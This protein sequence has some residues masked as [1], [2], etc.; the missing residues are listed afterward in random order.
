M[1]NE[2]KFKQ[3]ELTPTVNIT[4]LDS[5]YF[6][7]FLKDYKGTP[8]SHMPIELIYIDK[9]SQNVYEGNNCYTLKQG[10]IFIHKP[11]EVH[12]DNA[13]NCITTAYIISFTVDPD[14]IKPLFDKVITLSDENIYDLK[15][16]FSLIRSGKFNASSWS[17]YFGIKGE[18]KDNEEPEFAHKQKIKN[19]L[20]LVLID[21]IEK[22]D[23][24]EIKPNNYS[25]ATLELMSAISENIYK[26]LDL[27][28]LSQ[29][30]YYSKSYL[31]R[32]FKEDTNKTIV[33]FYYEK[34]IDEA[35]VLLANNDRSLTEISTILNFETV[36][37]FNYIFKK[38]VGIS[39]KQWQ[40]TVV[41]PMY[42]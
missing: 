40:K 7:T 34:K 2:I 8:E 37:Y 31:C 15:K 41:K 36:Q 6:C 17:F 22:Q 1:S 9:G 25:K 30:L 39:P 23:I 18:N 28:E 4:A 26:K 24:K 14:E 12:Y 35:K 13:N 5:A 38:Y 27:E 42:Y 16:V 10:Q 32:K 11:M 3:F 21:L 29:N 20:E 19:I 33:Q